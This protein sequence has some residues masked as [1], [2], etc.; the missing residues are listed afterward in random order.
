V[1][2]GHKIKQL[3]TLKGINQQELADK[4]FKTR[5]LVSYIEN[6]GKINHHTLQLFA[7][8]FKM[9]IEELEDF[10]MDMVSITK[11]KKVAQENNEL[12]KEN[13]VLKELVESQRKIITL[14]ENKKNRA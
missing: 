4:V 11:S 6:T 8:V 5:A 10:E 3:R 9:T 14:L 2:I 13:L 7:K 1:H 12:R